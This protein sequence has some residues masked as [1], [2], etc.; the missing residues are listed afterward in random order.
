MSRQ[1]YAVDEMPNDS[2]DPPRPSSLTVEC[3]AGYRGE[4]TPRRFFLHDRCFQVRELL[5]C[6]LAP[7]HRY[8]KVVA[9]DGGVYI[10]RHD[11]GHDLWELTMFAARGYLD[12]GG[13]DFREDS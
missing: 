7:K 5:D 1:W 13:P 12:G 9:D 4:Q 11:T 2:V 10:L 6:W 3:H 8:F